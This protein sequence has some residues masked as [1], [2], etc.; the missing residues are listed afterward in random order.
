MDGVVALT[1]QEQCK[2]LKRIH[3]SVKW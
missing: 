1:E 2:C 3:S